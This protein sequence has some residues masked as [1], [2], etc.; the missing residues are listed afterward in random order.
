MTIA[1]LSQPLKGWF[2]R[3]MAEKSSQRQKNAPTVAHHHALL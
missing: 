2:D 3:Q 1:I